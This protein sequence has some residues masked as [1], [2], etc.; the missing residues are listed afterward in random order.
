MPGPILQEPM[1]IERACDACKMRAS[2]L[3][4][5]QDDRPDLTPVYVCPDFQGC[6][7]RYRFGESPES[8]ARKRLRK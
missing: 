4:P 8:F 2:D 3:V 6:C 7:Q 5:I 1:F